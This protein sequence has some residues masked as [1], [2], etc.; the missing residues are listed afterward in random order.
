MSSG[1]A[2]RNPFFFPRMKY[3]AGKRH[4]RG[5]HSPGRLHTYGPVDRLTLDIDECVVARRR[6]GWRCVRVDPEHVATERHDLYRRPNFWADIDVLAL[7]MGIVLQAQLDALAEGLEN[8]QRFAARMNSQGYSPGGV[9]AP[10]ME[11]DTTS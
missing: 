7:V 11:G 6:E 1:Q 3:R 5:L 9:I 10:P 8:A 4:V 2:G